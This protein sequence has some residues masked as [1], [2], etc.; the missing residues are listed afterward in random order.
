[1]KTHYLLGLLL[2][3]DSQVGRLAF[4]PELQ[5]GLGYAWDKKWF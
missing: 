1:M 3:L 5:V 4:K 2:I